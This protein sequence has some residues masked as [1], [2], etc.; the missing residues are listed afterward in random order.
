[1]AHGL[2]AD[3]TIEATVDAGLRVVRGR[4]WVDPSL[5]AELVDPLPRLPEPAD[6]LRLIR[7]YPGIPN[8]GRIRWSSDGDGWVTFETE[9]PKRFGAIG[10]TR[11]GLFANGGWYPTPLL[12]G[13]LA[14]LDWQVEITL[15][16]RTGGAL[17]ASWGRDALRWTGIAERASLAVVPGGRFTPVVVNH[18]QVVLLTGRAAR[19]VL[20][21]E[22]ERELAHVP[23][24]VHGVAVEAPLRRRLVRHGPGLAYVSD[25]ALRLTP[26]FRFAHREA[27]IRGVLAAWTPGADRQLRELRA[28][29]T[30]DAYEIERAGNA[31]AGVLGALS[32]VP[33]VNEILASQRTP[34]YSE[35]LDRVHSGDP[36]RDDLAEV[37]DPITP[38]GVVVA[39]LDDRYGAGTGAC[40]A[41]TADQLC[42]IDRDWLASWRQPYPDQ[43]YRLRVDGSRIE[44][45]RDAPPGAP[46]EALVVEIDGSRETLLLPPGTHVVERDEPPRKVRIDPIRHTAQRSRSRDSY[47][48][49]YDV[50]FAAWLDAVNLDRRQVFGTLFTTLRRQYD[51]HNL[52]IGSLGNSQ[53]DLVAIDLAYLRKEG[54]LLDGWLRPHRLR[55]AVGFSVFNPRFA[56]FEAPIGLD[57]TL[58]WS[59]DTRVNIDFPLRGHRVSVVASGGVVP[60]TPNRWGNVSTNVL[61]VVSPHPRHAFVGRASAAWAW[62]TIPQ[63]RLTLGGAGLM[64]SIPILPACAGDQATDCTRLADGRALFTGEYRIAAIRGASVPLLLVWGSE[65]QLAA[66][67]EGI[68]A[69]VDDQALWSTGAT[70]GVHA[71]GDLLGAETSDIGL[72]AAWPLWFDDRLREVQRTPVPELYIRLQQAF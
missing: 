19:P 54:P 3:V 59:H 21:R 8:Q 14:P 64:R 57:T 68:L 15:P 62:S 61:G 41:R 6:D 1:M 42:G 35:I 31:A 34:F 46:I 70:L 27:L 69:S 29:V 55:A 2:A 65:L 49:R 24:P 13:H 47:P 30:A 58:S 50:T 45:V 44:I 43:D 26:G 16:A 12:D 9:L 17:N 32:W 39:Q 63:R 25:R 10:A 22:L 33:F 40:V 56:E 37:L 71:L 72:T 18:N 5:D 7:T 4:M 67:V 60:G 53:A 36:V 48:P 23:V 38:G 66:G 52:L 20:I 28:A 51:T 11:F